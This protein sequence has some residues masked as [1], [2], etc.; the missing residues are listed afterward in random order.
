M[1][2]MDPSGLY[3][4]WCQVF[5]C[6]NLLLEWKCCSISSMPLA[7]RKSA[8]CWVLKSGAAAYRSTFKSAI[9]IGGH[10]FLKRSRLL[11]HDGGPPKYWVG[12]RLL[13]LGVACRQIKHG[14]RDSWVHVAGRIQYL[15]W[16][17]TEEC[18]SSVQ[19]SMRR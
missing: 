4:F 2:W 18:P 1:V 6:R 9:N 15:G 8:T 17:L 3:L 16:A 13:S 12:G 10:L 7:A 19:L 14:R 11:E 5:W